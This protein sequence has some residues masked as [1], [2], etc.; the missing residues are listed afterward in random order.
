MSKTVSRIIATA[1]FAVVLVGMAAKS[2]HD[3]REYARTEAEHMG[4]DEESSKLSYAWYL[5]K[6]YCV[7]AYHGVANTAVVTIAALPMIAA[8]TPEETEES[9]EVL[10]I[11]T[12]E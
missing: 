9:S 11:T 4:L 12:T 8:W 5:T 7:G 10:S 3:A 2:V 6:C 1:N